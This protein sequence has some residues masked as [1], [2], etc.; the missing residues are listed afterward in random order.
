MDNASPHDTNDERIDCFD[1]GVRTCKNPEKLSFSC[2][3][4]GSEDRTSDEM[5]AKL[6]E[7]LRNLARGIGMHRGCVDYNLALEAYLRRA[8]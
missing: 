8:A 5:C 6:R 3:G 1:S 4:A 7:L 2:D